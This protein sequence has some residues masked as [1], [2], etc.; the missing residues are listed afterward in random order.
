MNS[1]SHSEGDSFN[2]II[3]RSSVANLKAFLKTSSLKPCSSERVPRT[4]TDE[5]LTDRMGTEQ[6][7]MNR[8]QIWNG[9]GT[10]TGTRVEWQHNAFCQAVPVTVGFF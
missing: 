8:E 6:N 9:Y 5:T 7:R 1:C 4:L 10:G 2:L 3:N